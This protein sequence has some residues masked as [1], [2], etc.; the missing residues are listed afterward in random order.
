MLVLTL[1]SLGCGTR[2]AVVGTDLAPA[3]GG[4]LVVEELTDEQR[5]I[6]LDIYGLPTPESRA[7][8]ATVYVVWLVSEDASR[9]EL[10]GRL[11]YDLIQRSGE[12]SAMTLMDRFALI[13]SAE[14]SASPQA[15]SR[16][17]VLKVAYPPDV[18]IPERFRTTVTEEPRAEPPP[19][20]APQPA[21][22]PAPTEPAPT[23]PA[24][25]AVEPAG[26]PATL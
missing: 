3:V 16:A 25:P 22:P 12:L 18:R 10:A 13:V 23:E 4:E 2:I 19:P 11:D 17:I 20:Q 7:D 15:P 9:I 5:S 14:S 1:L 8:G 6:D 21:N 24:A 26:P